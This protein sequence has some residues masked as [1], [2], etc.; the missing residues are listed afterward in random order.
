[1]LWLALECVIH[2]PD[3]CAWCNV[4]LHLNG[5]HPY[6]GCDRYKVTMLH[7][8]TVTRLQRY[9]VTHLQGYKQE[10]RFH[11][12]SPMVGLA[13]ACPNYVTP[14]DYVRCIK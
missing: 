14:Y 3:A 1:M 7:S 11:C 12:W 5:F 10:D 6:K 9:T 2:M 8:Y 4:G 13:K